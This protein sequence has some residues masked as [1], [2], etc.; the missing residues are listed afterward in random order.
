[1][2]QVALVGRISQQPQLRYTTEGKPYLRFPIA[3][4]SD[5]YDEATKQYKPDFIDCIIWGKTAETRAPYMNKGL[6]I[7]LTGQLRTRIDQNKEGFRY[8][9]TDVRV[10]TLKFLE[11]KKIVDDRSKQ[12]VLS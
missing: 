8:Q 7:S 4:E 10:E 11:S 5:V 2:N 3:V 6:L 1:M 9:R 12:G